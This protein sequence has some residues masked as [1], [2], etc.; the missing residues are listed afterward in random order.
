MI[1]PFCSHYS[2]CLNISISHVDL[3]GNGVLSILVLST[4]KMSTSFLKKV[5]VFQ[6]I[7]FKV[8]ALKTFKI[9]TDRYIKHADLSTIG[10]FWKSLVPF[11]RRTYVHSA[12]LK[13]KPLRKSILKWFCRKTCW[14]EQ[15]SIFTVCL[16]NHILE[17]NWL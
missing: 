7:Y 2:S 16:R 3:Y 4:K 1:G 10:L 12:G 9:S 14:K 5:F 15:S 11:F 6:K 17:L 13:I 8:T